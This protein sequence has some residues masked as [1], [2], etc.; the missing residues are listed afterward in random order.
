MIYFK[1][2]YAD[3]KVKIQD[4]ALGSGGHGFW[5]AFFEYIWALI[6]MKDASLECIDR[7]RGYPWYVVRYNPKH[8]EQ[9]GGS[10]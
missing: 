5:S 3:S 9:K 4:V 10:E 6:F 8:P 2:Q 1:K 7:G